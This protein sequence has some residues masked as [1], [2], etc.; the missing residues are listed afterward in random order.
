MTIAQDQFTCALV[1][2]PATVTPRVV[3]RFVV[4]DILPADLAQPDCGF[5][6]GSRSAHTPPSIKS[7]ITHQI[8]DSTLIYCETATLTSDATLTHYSANGTVTTEGLG[9][10]SGEYAYAYLFS[11]AAGASAPILAYKDLGVV[12]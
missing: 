2:A 1:S 10:Y 5:G 9:A 11:D 6:L 3:A 12:P 8:V 4:R 7:D